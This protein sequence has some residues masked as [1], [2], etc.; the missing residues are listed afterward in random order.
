MFKLNLTT[1]ANHYVTCDT[2]SRV[3]QLCIHPTDLIS[4]RGGTPNSRLKIQT[5][6]YALNWTIHKFVPTHWTQ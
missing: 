3:S 1:N 6:I 4:A 5:S 2:A